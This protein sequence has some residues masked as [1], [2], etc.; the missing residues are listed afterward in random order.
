[1]L[2]QSF[3]VVN[4]FQKKY[5][6]VSIACFSNHD[7]DVGCNEEENDVAQDVEIHKSLF[8]VFKSFVGCPELKFEIIFD[9]S[10]RNYISAFQDQFRF[11]PNDFCPKLQ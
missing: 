6:S 1:M 3:M 7:D 10:F 5:I 4:Q 2:A 8:Y 9:E 11:G